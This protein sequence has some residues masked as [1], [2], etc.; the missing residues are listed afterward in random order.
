[1]NR[2]NL[3]ILAAATAVIISMVCLFACNSKQKEIE[4]QQKKLIAD[5]IRD[6]KIE[7]EYNKR[8]P[9]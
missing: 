7:Y 1:M 4:L 6:A 3:K 2:L 9:A 8:N 5:S